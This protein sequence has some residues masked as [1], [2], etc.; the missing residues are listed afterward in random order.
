MKSIKLRTRQSDTGGIA[1]RKG[2]AARENQSKTSSG[3]EERQARRGKRGSLINGDSQKQADG[4]ALYL[5]SWTKGSICR[6]EISRGPPARKSKHA[7]GLTIDGLSLKDAT[8]ADEKSPVHPEEGSI[9][10][11]QSFPPGG[12][13][14][15]VDC[16]EKQLIQA[17]SGKLFSPSEETNRLS[18]LARETTGPRSR[19]GR[20]RG[21]SKFH[22]ISLSTSA[23]RGRPLRHPWTVY[24]QQR[25]QK[26]D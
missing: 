24:R 4:A 9:P 7:C 12:E 1:P 23:R 8:P 20:V 14:S 6:H 26:F 3:E 19:T 25:E 11:L 17:C 18:P 22:L 15:N 2:Q 21:C 5:K 16:A 13:R 10:S